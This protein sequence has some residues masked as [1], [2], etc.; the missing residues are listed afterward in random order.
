M[1]YEM[2][3]PGEYIVHCQMQEH[4]EEHVIHKQ[5]LSCARFELVKP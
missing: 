1:T 5:S 2:L 4:L 3:M